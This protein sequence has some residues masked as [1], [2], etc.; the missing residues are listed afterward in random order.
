MNSGIYRITNPKGAIYI[1]Q[2]KRLDKRETE[3][4]TLQC[5]Q[6]IKIFNSIK[7]Y[8]WNNHIFE[9][10]KFCEIEKLNEFERS[11]GLF[12]DVL[13]S[14]NLNL[15]LPAYNELPKIVS[16]ETRIKMS[17]S[18]KGLQRRK[19]CKLSDETKLKISNSLKGKKSSNETKLKISISSKGR[20]PSVETRL[21]TSLRFSKKV[22]NLKTFEIFTSALEV[23]KK[24]GINYSTLKGQL[25]GLVSN[26]TDFIYLENY[27]I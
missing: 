20:L 16:I 6:Q 12:Y 10:I 5:K 2:S 21:K 26:R 18:C 24:S 15:N 11:L 13:N 19:G 25:N 14:K 17:N 27:N 9:I 23:S 8:G 4:K 3:Y 22:I 1:G 7:K